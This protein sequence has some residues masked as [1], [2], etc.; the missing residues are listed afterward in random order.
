MAAADLK[1]PCRCS[2][3]LDQIEQPV[4]GQSASAFLGEVVTV[5]HLAVEVNEIDAD[6]KRWLLN[7]VAL[8]AAVE[9]A[10]GAGPVAGWCEVAWF[11][12]VTGTCETQFEYALTDSAGGIR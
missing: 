3:S 12:R 10:V 8:A 11:W 1:H 4:G 6:W 5:I 9:V 7:R 2:T